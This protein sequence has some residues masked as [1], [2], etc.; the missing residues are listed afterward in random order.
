[1]STTKELSPAALSAGCPDIGVYFACLA[2]Y[3]S[4]VLHGA[5]CDLEEVTDAEDLQAVIDYAIA[6]SPTAGAEEWEV[7]DSSGLPHCLSGTEWPDLKDLAAFA[8]TLQE[9]GSDDAEPYRLLCNNL[10]QL[11]SADDFRESFA[12]E[13]D[14]EEDFAADLAEQTGALPDQL[15][16]P[17]YSIDW[18][19]AWRDLRCG[20]DYYSDRGAGGALYIFRNL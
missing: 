16:W 12:G 10:G 18:S 8:E 6:T 14:S 19:A 1:M 9:I 13:W 3:N 11:V 4:G 2:S 7:H 5:W 17:L 15:A 20:G